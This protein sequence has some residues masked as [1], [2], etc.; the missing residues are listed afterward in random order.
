MVIL[1][2]ALLSLVIGVIVC[3]TLIGSKKVPS[4]FPGR[5]GSAD[6]D[7]LKKK[8]L[9]IK[10][11]SF[12]EFHKKFDKFQYG[13]PINSQ[14]GENFKSCA[15]YKRGNPVTYVG[16]YRTPGELSLKELKNRT[17]ELKVG[18]KENGK[19]LIYIGDM[20]YTKESDPIDLGL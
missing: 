8:P 6:I 1:F 14:T 7:W 3:R 13:N 17:R 2:I 9:F 4:S 19:Y 10:T 5:E 11:W 20:P 15:F 12:E 18:L 16:F